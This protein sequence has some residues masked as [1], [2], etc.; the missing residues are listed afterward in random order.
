MNSPSHFDEFKK[1]LKKRKGLNVS[2]EDGNTAL[3]LA[4]AKG[5]AK[6]VLKLLRAGADTQ[7]TNVEGET[8]LSLAATEAHPRVVRILLESGATWENAPCRAF[9]LLMRMPPAS[10]WW[11]PR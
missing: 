9:W 10:S 2:D 7:C 6:T 1:T 5:K 8:A 3:M 4:A 11:L